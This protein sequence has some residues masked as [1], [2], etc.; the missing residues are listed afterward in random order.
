MN[1]VTFGNYLFDQYTYADMVRCIY[2]T[3]KSTKISILWKHKERTPLCAILYS[4]TENLEYL[5]IHKT[6][7]LGMAT[8]HNVNVTIYIILYAYHLL[9]SS[10]PT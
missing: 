7:S 10:T 4:K 1:D 3:N 2:I 5:D 6:L 9:L 8:N